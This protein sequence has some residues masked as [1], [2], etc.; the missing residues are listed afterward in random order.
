MMRCRIAW[1]DGFALLSSRC[2]YELVEKAVMSGCPMLVKISAPTHLALARAAEAGLA[3]KVLAR[4][5][6]LLCPA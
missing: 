2:S 1:E 5:D 3:L 4:A 6:A